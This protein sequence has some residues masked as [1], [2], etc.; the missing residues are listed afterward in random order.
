M[1]QYSIK[2]PAEIGAQLKELVRQTG[3]RA[4]D[5]ISAWIAIEARDREIDLPIPGIAVSTQSD[6]IHVQLDDC[7]MAPMTVEEVTAFA[8]AIDAVVRGR[9]GARI[10][11]IP[12]MVTT[13]RGPGPALTIKIDDYQRTFALGVARSIEAKL[14]LAAKQWDDHGEISI[15]A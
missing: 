6:G 12:E 14:R 5:L 4:S 1:T 11:F 2:L 10:M 9:T 13:Q 7:K 15:D 3:H 8:D